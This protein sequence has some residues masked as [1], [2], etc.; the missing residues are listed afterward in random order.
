M[1]GADPNADGIRIADGAAS[2]NRPVTAPINA[3][4]TNL[5]NCGW[6]AAAMFHVKRSAP[7][8][9]FLRRCGLVVGLH[10][11]QSA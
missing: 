9:A 2:R 4:L 10:L 8:A 5:G 3:K 1:E 11:Q 6:C 7:F